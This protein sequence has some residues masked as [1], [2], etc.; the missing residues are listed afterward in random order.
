MHRRASAHGAGE[1]VAYER[2]EVDPDAEELSRRTGST[3]QARF[4]TA[5]GFVAEQ[6]GARVVIDNEFDLTG[7]WSIGF[8]ANVG[9]ILDTT[10]SEY[11]TLVFAGATASAERRQRQASP[12][13]AMIR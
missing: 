1:G 7:N 3:R 12:A 6:E 10:A 8:S 2:R 5:L 13:F 9:D 11:W 4:S